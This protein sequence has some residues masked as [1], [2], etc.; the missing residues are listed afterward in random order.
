MTYH[1]PRLWSLTLRYSLYFGFAWGAVGWRRW[2]KRRKE[3]IAQ[4]WPSVEAVI[5]TGSVSPV[6]KTSC[7]LATLRYTY[8]VDEYRTG[9][10]LHE[11]ARES[12]AD[13]FIRQLANK[14]LP[15]R[16]NPAKP[17]YSVLETATVEQHANLD[18]SLSRT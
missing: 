11:F 3:S 6:P 14:R 18:A 1:L 16:Y 4:G 17:E 15:I 12:D 13:E 7:F 10:Y 2:Q 5:L 9:T 8:Y